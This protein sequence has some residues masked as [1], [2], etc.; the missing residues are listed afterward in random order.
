ME[1]YVKG[2]GNREQGKGPCECLESPT[3]RTI[4]TAQSRASPQSPQETYD[5][6]SHSP[7]LG[8]A[9]FRCLR[10]PRVPRQVTMSAGLT[11]VSSLCTSYGAFTLTTTMRKAHIMEG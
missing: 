5:G 3:K 11:Y 9:A 8:L 1:V 6:E 7:S 10:A 2:K 4:Y